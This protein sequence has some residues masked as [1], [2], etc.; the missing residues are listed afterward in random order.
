MIHWSSPVHEK[1]IGLENN[2]NFLCSDINGTG[3]T[4]RV[5]TVS[6]IVKEQ[7][8]KIVPEVSFSSLLELL[9]VLSGETQVLAIKIR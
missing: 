8:P 1:D 2:L 3:P 5:L 4:R 9:Y 7:Q 6:W